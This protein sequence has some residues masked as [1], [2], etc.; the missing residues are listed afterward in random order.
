M[1]RDW[2]PL[3]FTSHSLTPAASHYSMFDRELLTAYHIVSHFQPFIEGQL[4]TIFMDHH[5]LT[6]AVHCHMNLWSLHQYHHLSALMELCSDIV[7]QPGPLD[8]G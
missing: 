8:S 5:P 7:Y 1:G 3:S 2:H 6:Q 4:C